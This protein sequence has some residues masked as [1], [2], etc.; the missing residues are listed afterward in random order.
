M[1]VGGYDL[2]SDIVIAINSRKACS[3]KSTFATGAVDCHDSP[4][5]SFIKA[6]KAQ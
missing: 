6:S 2:T 1:Q 4:G 5:I 3:F